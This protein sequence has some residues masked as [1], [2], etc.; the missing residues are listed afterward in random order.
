MTHRSRIV[1]GERVPRGLSPRNWLLRQNQHFKAAP[2]VPVLKIDKPKPIN[3]LHVHQPGPALTPEKKAQRVSAV[4]QHTN[5]VKA[6][7]K[8]NQ[9]E[10]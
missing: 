7:L 4:R 3:A 1:N 6:I 5:E 9:Y 10:K 2:K 8:Q